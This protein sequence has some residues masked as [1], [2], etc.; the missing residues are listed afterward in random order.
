MLRKLCVAK[1]E[2]KTNWVLCPML[3]FTTRLPS[4]RQRTDKSFPRNKIRIRIDFFVT[5]PFVK[6]FG[7]RKTEYKK[8]TLSELSSERVFYFAEI[9][10]L[11]CFVVVFFRDD[12]I[13]ARFDWNNSCAEYPIRCFVSRFVLCLIAFL[14]AYR[15]SRDAHKRY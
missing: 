14:S 13:K 10:Y 15:N 1:A 11:N 3:L 5:F 8:N 9:L 6:A 7:R 4:Q 12:T 2:R